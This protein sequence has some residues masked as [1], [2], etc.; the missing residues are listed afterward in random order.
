MLM[1]SPVGGY[2]FC[3]EYHLLFNWR[4]VPSTVTNTGK[5][6]ALLWM[7]QATTFSMKINLLMRVLGGENPS[8]HCHLK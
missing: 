2:C 3:E 8:P 6:A 5:C 1:F 7:L 4:P